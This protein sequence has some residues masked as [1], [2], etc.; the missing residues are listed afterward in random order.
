MTSSSKFVIIASI[1]D[2]M[3]ENRNRTLSQIHGLP[4]DSE[5]ISFFDPNDFSG[6]ERHG[7]LNATSNITRAL[8]GA[9]KRNS[10]FEELKAELL[11]FVKDR[12]SFVKAV[13]K[14]HP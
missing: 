8:E 1:G 12:K 4:Q 3:A 10:S 9:L 2:M 11:Q 7:Y 13:K 5:A 14:N 6:F